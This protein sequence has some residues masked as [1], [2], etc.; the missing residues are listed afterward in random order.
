MTKWWVNGF[1]VQLSYAPKGGNNPGY[2]V[3]A[4]KT[5]INGN[6]PV[7]NPA[8]TNT[9]NDFQRA[10]TVCL[11]APD[12]TVTVPPLPTNLFN[13]QLIPN[14]AATAPA[15][16]NVGP[17]VA[18]ALLAWRGT[19]NANVASAY[20]DVFGDPGQVVFANFV[21]E[22]IKRQITISKKGSDGNPPPVDGNGKPIKPGTFP[23]KAGP[24]AAEL[25]GAGLLT[26]NRVAKINRVKYKK[27]RVNGKVKKGKIFVKAQSP[28][29]K[30]RLKLS[31]MGVNKKGSWVTMRTIRK[32]IKANTKKFVKVKVIRQ[33]RLAK[34]IRRVDAVIIR[35][36][37]R[38]IS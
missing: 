33:K 6:S 19:D 11:S 20:F 13:N 18:C 2:R 5:D 16:I 15:G 26:T 4:W 22:Q 32:T 37:G 29:T 12:G 38:L 36:A 24:T 1:N 14:V 35:T 10:E 30:L 25:K 9:D 34:R 28:T 31:L 23:E 7:K 3:T 27:V 8:N 17:H 21:T